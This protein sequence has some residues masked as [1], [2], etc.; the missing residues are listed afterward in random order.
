M[1]I[2]TRKRNESFQIGDDIR[3]VV[4]DIRGDKV[5]IG[6]DAPLS[7]P[8]VRTEIIN[9]AQQRA[10]GRKLPPVKSYQEKWKATDA[11]TGADDGRPER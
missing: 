11:E 3:I 1:L 10:G 8:I 9:K 6:I 5:R 4:V 2:L 7:R